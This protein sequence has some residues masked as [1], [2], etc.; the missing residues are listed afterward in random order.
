ILFLWYIRQMHERILVRGVNWVG[1]AVMTLPALKALRKTH[2]DAQI[3]L[4]VKPAVAPVFEKNPFLDEVILYSEKGVAGRLALARRLRKAHFTSAILFQNAFDAAL[5]AWLSGV[6]ERIGY[7]RD[8][9]GMLLTKRIPYQGDDKKV[10]H[11]E[12]YLRLLREAGIAAEHSRPWIHLTLAERLAARA[13]LEG[14]KRPVLGINP[15]AAYGSAKRWL[16]ERFAEVA[17]WFMADTKGSVVLFGGTNETPIA[18][19]IEKSVWTRKVGAPGAISPSLVNLSGNT[20]LRELVALISECDLFLGNDSGPMHIAY[21]VGTPLVALFGSTDPE[22]TGPVGEGNRVIRSGLPCSPCFARTCR[23]R[24]MQC[25]DEITSDDVY[26]A[27]KEMMFGRPAVFFDR[28]GTLCEDADYLAGREDFRLLPGVDDL[29]KLKTKGFAL[30][31]VTN[32]SGVAKGLVE[33][34][35]VQ[36]INKDFVEKFGFDGFYYCPHGPAEHCSCRKPEPGMAHQARVAYGIDLRRSYVVGD[37][38]ADMAFARS[39]GA[40]GVLVGTGQQQNSSYADFEVRGLQEA[41]ALILGA[42]GRNG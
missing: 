2:T 4:L 27:L 31:G 19:E 25:M 36:E 18:R 28:D 35:F 26:L 5:V 39:I 12:Y 3:S 1:D 17:L 20:S 9:R 15:G 13:A 11:V 22:L 21:A 7:D 30:I 33:E 34:G 6:P 24:E 38:D 37:K 14:V 41:V 16:P 29:V 42:E 8:G 40:K 10:H 32:Q 23:D